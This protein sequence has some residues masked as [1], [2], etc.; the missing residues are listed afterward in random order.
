MS[1]KKISIITMSLF[2]AIGLYGCARLS[3]PEI[4]TSFESVPA[5]TS[6]TRA[7]NTKDLLGS[8]VAVGDKLP[9]I[10]LTDRNMQSK[11]LDD[12]KG[13][14]LLLSIAP[15]LDTQ[16]CERQTHL[17]ADANEKELPQDILRV[18][19]TRDLPFAHS[20]FAEH[21]D[22]YHIIY[23]SDYRNADFGLGT[24]LLMDDIRLL[25]R[26]VMVIDKN[27]T[28]RYMQVVPE[29]SLLPDMEKAFSVA[30]QID[31]E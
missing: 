23:L 26:A 22:F 25:A 19:I 24:G 18:T 9:K 27:G 29:V 30:R 4:P 1:F 16:V 3:I 2:F 7:G 5:G 6:V 8:A 15:S 10:M 17:L 12:Y 28:I 20:R 21:T 11:S 31:A 13:K 14:T